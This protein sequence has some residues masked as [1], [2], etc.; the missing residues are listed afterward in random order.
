MGFKRQDNDDGDQVFELIALA[1]DGDHR[2]FH[3]LMGIYRER[4]YQTCWSLTR[5]SEDASDVMQDVF[6][7]VYAALGSFKG[8]SKFGTWLHRIT[9]N[10][11]LDFLRKEARHKSKRVYNEDEN[12]LQLQDQFRSEAPKQRDSVFY[13]ELQSV[14]NVA[15][16]QLPRR[17]KEVF[18]LRYYQS[19]DIKE[20]AEVTKCA[21][22]SVKRHL[23][24]AQ[25]R[26]REI[27][28]EKGWK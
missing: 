24:R 25:L 4:I 21:E 17:Q 3:E 8:K 7:R 13:S 18:V 26:L 28:R 15:I 20:I 9:L 16:E 11:A 14:I 6:L 1:C 5:N 12:D 23:H 22:G 27:M 19:L 2:A 10:T